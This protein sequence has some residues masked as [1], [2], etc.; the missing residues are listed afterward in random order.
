MLRI[1]RL[2]VV[3]L[4]G[5]TAT[6]SAQMFVPT[7]RDTL[8]GLPGVEV[9]VENVP[10]ELERLGLTSAGLRDHLER[11]LREGGVALYAS[12]AENP[13]PAKP[14]LYVHLNPLELPGGVL[15]VAVQVHLRQIL[16]SAV[17]GSQVVNAM[18]WDAHTIVAVPAARPD[19]LRDT[20]DDLTGGFVA[21]W[22]AVR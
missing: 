1:G 16:R 8:R 13:S 17:T 12:Q 4:A 5:W 15:A 21:D 14:Y 3:A 6:P 20:I 2:V 11:R 10:P 18:T 9:V 7:G 22:R 19:V